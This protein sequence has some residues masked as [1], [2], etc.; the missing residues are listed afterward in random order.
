MIRMLLGILSLIKETAALEQAVTAITAN[1]IVRDVE[2]LVV[3]ARAEQIP[4]ICSAIG[5][6]L[7]IGSSTRSLADVLLDIVTSG[8]FRFDLAAVLF[9]ASTHRPRLLDAA[10]LFFLMLETQH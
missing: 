5:L 2:S 7:K 9:F 1:D 6:L 8:S 10:R 4:R 3:T